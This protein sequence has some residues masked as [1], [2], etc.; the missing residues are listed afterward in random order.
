MVVKV[1]SDLQLPAASYERVSSDEQAREGFSLEVQAE[2]NIK[3]INDQGWSL[4]DRYIDA[5][6]SA[7][8]LNRPDMKRLLSD[9]D[10][11]N[12][13]VVVVHKLDRLTRNVGDLHE[14]LS[15]FERKEIKLVSISENIDTSSAMGRMF[16]YMLGIFAQWYRENLSEEVIKGQRKRAES[17]LRNSS[18]RPYGYNVN[19]ED[20][21]LYINEE[22]AVIVRRIFDQYTT[23]W[24][25]IKISQEL[26]NEGI[27]SMLGGL[28]YESVIGDMVINPSYIGATHWKEKSDDESERII[29]HDTHEA[30]VTMEIWEE[31]QKVS[32]RRLEGYLSKSSYDFPYATVVKCGECGRSY[33]GKMTTEKGDTKRPRYRCSGNRRVDPCYAGDIGEKKL[34]VLFLDFLDSFKFDSIQPDKKINEKDSTKEIKRLS[35]MIDEAEL[36]RKNYTRAMGSGKLDYTLY[37]EL[38]DEEARKMIPWRE[39]LSKLQQSTSG[40]SVRT[41]KDISQKIDHLRTNWPNLD[42]AQRKFVIQQLFD[43]LVIKKTDGTWAITG[44]KLA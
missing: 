11:G 41:A 33:H 13:K 26:N 30:I 20:L 16:V 5:G 15:V 3:H 10:A 23:G 6:K 8:N 18:K 34:D 9:I 14:L 39:E 21:S 37:E 25:K 32:K 2:K 27:P 40:P 1:K 29:V 44:Y 35:K 17:G 38:M 42:R 43:V 12:I 22:E 4:Y 31:A 19:K 28:W 36:K 7:K 24:G